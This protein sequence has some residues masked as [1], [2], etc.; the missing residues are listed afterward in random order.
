MNVRKFIV[1]DKLV[2]FGSVTT[3]PG[4]GTCF[5]SRSFAA[6]LCEVSSGWSLDTRKRFQ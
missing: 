1:G 6:V 4:K 2:L 3:R 5:G